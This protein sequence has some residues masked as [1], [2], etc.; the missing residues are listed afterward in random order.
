MLKFAS[1]YANLAELAQVYPTGCTP[2]PQEPRDYSDNTYCKTFHQGI[3]KIVRHISGLHVDVW[4][5]IRVYCVPVVAHKVRC[6]GIYTVYG[7]N[8]CVYGWMHD[9]RV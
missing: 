3:G 6:V 4:V 2:K 8:L 9:L 1:G 5:A 7:S